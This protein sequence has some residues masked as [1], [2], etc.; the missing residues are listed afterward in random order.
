MDETTG[1]LL[2][3]RSKGFGGRKS[4]IAP[5]GEFTYSDLWQASTGLAAELVDNK[6]DLAE[7]RVAFL[8]PPGFRYAAAL[9]G[10]WRAGGVAVPLA[11]SHPRPELEYV[12][13]DAEA[14]ILVAA[15]EF[16]DRLHPIA[17]D[18]GLRLLVYD[19][20]KTGPVRSFPVLDQDRRAMIVY[21]SG[22]TGRP[23]GVVTT[24]RQ[25]QAQI[26]TLVE[27][28]G[29]RPEDRILHVL[30][31]HHVHGIVN[32]LLCALWTGA[33][34]EILPRFE[35]Q[36]AWDRLVSGDITLFM[37]V[38]TIYSRLITAWEAFADDK[39]AEISLKASS[40]RLMVSGSAALPI[41]VLDKWRQITGHFLLERYGMTEIG[42]ALSNPLRGERRA[43]YVG[44]PLPGVEARI[45][46][47]EG[48]AINSGRPGELQIKG[49]GVFQEY[50]QRP[51][52]TAESFVDGWFRTGD[53]AVVENGAYRILGRSSVDI[54]KTGGYKVSALEIEEVLREYPAVAECAVVGVEDEEW[55][56]RVAA[57]VILK[58]GHQLDSEEIKAWARER[59]APYKVPS[60]MIAVDDLPRNPMGKVLKPEVMKMVP[61]A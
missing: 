19:R 61:R 53:T 58:S 5:E 35:T 48:R 45:V 51:E 10:I 44:S 4:L 47:E 42:M 15:S 33:A 59:I 29:W 7:S 40:L 16:E 23:K 36:V 18:L 28:W 3:D 9:W 41:R 52:A 12:V 49:P 54:I 22:T 6:P 37:A 60:L 24:H 21:T 50:W 27:A 55:G 11:V 2:L 57:A 39:K 56:Q 26:T 25:I 8:F 13:R 43:G 34:C 17:K 31:L 38:P 32:I 20:S 30:P 1:I 14:A 46:D